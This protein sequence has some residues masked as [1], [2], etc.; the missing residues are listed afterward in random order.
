MYTSSSTDTYGTT[1]VGAIKCGLSLCIAFAAIG[2]RAGY[3]EALLISIIGTILY[4]LNRQLITKFAVDYGGSIGIFLFGG[5]MGWMLSLLLTS[6]Q[7]GPS[8]T[9]HP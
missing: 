2:G 3:F 9:A 1:A 7:G 4:E 8:I 6:K 5:A